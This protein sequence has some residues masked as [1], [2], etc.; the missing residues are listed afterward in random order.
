MCRRWFFSMQQLEEWE[1]RAAIF[2]FDAGMIREEAEAKA[3]AD[4]VRREEQEYFEELDSDGGV[5]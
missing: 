4:L 3:Y 1:E 2:E 5:L